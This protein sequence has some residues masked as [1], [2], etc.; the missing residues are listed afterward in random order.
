[1]NKYLCSASVTRHA[2]QS[3]GSDTRCVEGSE[4]AALAAIVFF[5][6]KNPKLKAFFL[7]SFSVFAIFFNQPQH[8]LQQ[9][10]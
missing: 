5:N 9:Q 6:H 4:A 7:E 8:Q 3:S 10:P 2:I 1:L